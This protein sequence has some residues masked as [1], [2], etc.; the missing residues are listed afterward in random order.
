MKLK[1]D[2][3]YSV[4]PTTKEKEKIRKRVGVPPNSAERGIPNQLYTNQS[5][6]NYGHNVTEERTTIEYLKYLEQQREELENKIDRR[7]DQGLNVKD[8]Y[9]QLDRIDDEINKLKGDSK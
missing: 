8:L 5:Y 6:S 4:L 2:N 9:Y 3:T 1:I 7:M